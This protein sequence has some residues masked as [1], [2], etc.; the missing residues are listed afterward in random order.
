MLDSGNRP[1]PGRGRAT[2]HGELSHVSLAL[3]IERGFDHTTIDDIA[4]AA[5]I[6][7]R[8]FFRYFPSK[9]DLPWGDFTPLLEAMR[10]RL[11]TTDPG[12]PLIEALRRA[13]LA[14]NDYPPH[15]MLYHRDRMWL[16]LNVPSLQTHSSLRYAEW[17]RVIAEYAAKR[18]GDRLD[19]LA[20]QAIAWA[21][22]GLCLSAYEQWLAHDGADLLELLDRS[23]MTA[24]SIFG[25][26]DASPG[27]SL[28]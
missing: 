3:F 2:T 21:C 25:F 8:T 19:A 13:V 1:K 16:L 28:K 18:L 11:D 22:L 23:F 26:V 17:R 24:E 9:N 14:F 12:V 20:P 7:R 5:G 4:A 15:E 6:S 10:Q 27:V